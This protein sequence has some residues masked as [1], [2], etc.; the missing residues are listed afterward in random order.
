MNAYFNIFP[1][2]AA[3]RNMV[4]IIC[5]HEIRPV[6]DIPQ[7]VA[8]IEAGY[9]SDGRGEV[10]PFP[11]SRIEARGTTLAWLGASIPPED[12][13]GFRS[14][15][16][17]ATGSDVGHQVV[18]L[19]TH[20]S[21]K[22]RALFLGRLVGNLRTGAAIAAAFHLVDP[23]LHNFGLLGTGYQA[24]NAIACLAA[25]FPKS[26]MVAWSPNTERRTAFKLWAEANLGV[27]VELKED[28]TGV[29]RETQSVALVTASERPVVIPGMLQEPHLLLS[30]NAYRR[31]EIDLSLLESAKEVWTDSVAQASGPGTLFEKSEMRSRLSPLV[32]GLEDGKLR[33]KQQ[34]RI[35]INTGA[36]W[37][38]VVTAEALL[39]LATSRNIGTEIELPL[40]SEQ[41]RVF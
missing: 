30:I 31:P 11:R 22:L 23:S 39:E 12:L 16:Y 3:L 13:L 10:V 19:Y 17:G 2:V 37:E 20:G 36:A 7:I 40:D 32:R 6:I 18:A 5:D 15:L 35:I 28:A 8:R 33:D 24:R 4:R 14:Y 27:E 29:L 1:V 21:M 26:R 34:N 9:R 25:T 38:E 41:H